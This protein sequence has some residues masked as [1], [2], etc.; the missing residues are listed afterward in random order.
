MR[1]QPAH[2][3]REAGIDQPLDQRRRDQAAR[4]IVHQYPVLR[5]RAPLQQ[6]AQALQHGLGPRGTAAGRP[7]PGC[8]VGQ[9]GQHVVLRGND[10]QRA[11]QPRYPTNAA[12]VCSTSGRP[13]SG[14]YCLG[15]APPARNPAPA[16]GSSAHSRGGAPSALAGVLRVGSVIGAG[17][18]RICGPPWISHGFTQAQY[19][20]TLHP[21]PVRP[22]RPMRLL[23]AELAQRE[24]A[25]GR[26]TAI[27]TAEATDA[28]RLL[29][30]IRFF[31][32]TCAAR[33]S[34]TGRR[35]PTT[36]SR[37]TRT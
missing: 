27:V 10:D 19:R 12:S 4:R 15:W 2:R 31:A 17:H 7:L 9:R 36:P 6:Y 23:L 35:C 25:A 26:P 8:A 11:G 13:A 3:V 20:Q 18:S 16:Q 24:K 37:R 34:R 21:A 28:Q 33:C 22:A 5:L 32:P 29:D 30:E 14:W 1:Q